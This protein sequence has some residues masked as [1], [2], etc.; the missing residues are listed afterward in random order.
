MLHAVLLIT[1]ILHP[2]DVYFPM[3]C[4]VLASDTCIMLKYSY[5][6]AGPWKVR[7]DE[8]KR[9][10]PEKMAKNGRGAKPKMSS[11]SP[12]RDVS[13]YGVKVGNRCRQVLHYDLDSFGNV[14]DTS[15]ENRA[16]NRGAT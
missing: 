2:G 15:L 14:A 13:K 4:L 1:L 8:L 12:R 9:F 7:E 11:D 3:V 10:R 16:K 5:Y 6:V